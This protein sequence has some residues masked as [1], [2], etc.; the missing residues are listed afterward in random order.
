PMRLLLVEDNLSLADWLSRALR[1]NRYTVDCAHDGAQADHLL[2]TQSY[3]LVILDLSLPKL[4]G[5][6]VL[7]RLRVRGS[8]VPVLILTATNT[9]QGRIQGL[10]QGADD[11]VAKPFDLS[12]LDARIRAILR[13]ANQSANPILECGRLRY[14]GNTRLFSISEK[15]LPLPPREHAVLETLILKQGKT[16]S[17]QAIASSLFALTDTTAPDAI[18]IYVSR[19][20]KK[21]EPSDAAL[22]T[23]RG[24]GYLLKRRSA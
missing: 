5:R 11:Y 13:R 8:N 16:V 1:D 7:R 6:E 14:D 15:P 21:L 17:K 19:L 18:E 24:L 22:V 12:E 23:L 2:R 20:R 9:V 3:D 10:N 4:D